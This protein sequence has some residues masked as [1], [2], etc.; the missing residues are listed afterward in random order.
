MPAPRGAREHPDSWETHIGPSQGTREQHALSPAVAQTHTPPAQATLSTPPPPPHLPSPSGHPSHPINSFCSF[1]APDFFAEA[2]GRAQ[3]PLLPGTLVARFLL[4]EEAGLQPQEAPGG[5]GCTHQRS[6]CGV[7]AWGVPWRDPPGS[8]HPTLATEQQGGC[9]G[10][11][12]GEFPL[13]LGTSQASVRFG[14]GSRSWPECPTRDPRTHVVSLRGALFRRWGKRGNV[15]S[16]G[17]GWDSGSGRA[18]GLCADPPSR[19]GPGEPSPGARRSSERP[20][21]TGTHPSKGQPWG[22][23]GRR[24]RSCF[25]ARGRPAALAG[26]KPLAPSAP[27]VILA[28]VP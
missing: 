12:L 2:P 8:A 25:I 10:G 27:V 11:G 14:N 17:P 4:A 15:L 16:E 13:T 26:R 23:A 28:L 19:V 7:P 21:P 6:P 22:G 24:W 3:Q 1:E 9:G 20:G 18:Q 5:V